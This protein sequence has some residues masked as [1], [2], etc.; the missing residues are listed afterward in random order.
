[1]QVTDGAGLKAWESSDGSL[2]YYSDDQQ[3]IWRMPARG[4]PPMFVLRL[5][6]NTAF[7]GEWIPRS[8]G[9]YWLNHDA[10]PRQAIEWFDFGTSRSTPLI[11]PAGPYDGG[12]GFTVSKDGLWA[13]FSQKDYHGA[14]IML[15]D[16]VR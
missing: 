6:E 16:R 14:D 13:V 15:V 12:S 8:N 10:S 4:G 5:A 3:T 1:M 2:L 7:G 9:V 11:V